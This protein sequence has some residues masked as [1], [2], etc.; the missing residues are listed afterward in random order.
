MISYTE[1]IMFKFDFNNSLL[2]ANFCM[3]FW[4]FLLNLTVGAFISLFKNPKSTGLVESLCIGLV[5]MYA[6]ASLDK[7]VNKTLSTIPY[8]LIFLELIAL[9]RIIGRQIEKAEVNPIARSEA[10]A[11]LLC[12]ND[13]IFWPHT[14]RTRIKLI[15][16]G[17]TWVQILKRR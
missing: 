9:G 16:C 3:N 6:W 13:H 1:S 5:H 7:N 2:H 17:P 11:T 15:F 8:T 14:L 4:Y 12:D 10:E